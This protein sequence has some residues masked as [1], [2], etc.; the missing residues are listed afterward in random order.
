MKFA[1]RPTGAGE[2]FQLLRDG[3][4]R[5]RS[6]LATITGQARSTIAAR[7]DVLTAAGLITSVGEASSTG[8]RRPATFAF[9]PTARIVL[10]VD[11]GA[12]HARVAVADLAAAIVVNHD[13]PL[14]IADGPEKVLARVI[15]LGKDLVAESGHE[16]SDL[17]AVGIGLPG[18]VEHA[19]GR[20]VAPP[21]MPG[22]DGYDVAGT[23]RRAFGAPALVDNDVNLM[24]VGEQRTSWHEHTNMLFVKVATGIGSGIILDGTLRRGAQGAAGDIGHIALPGFSEAPCN[25]GNYGCL[26]AVAGGAALARALRE[27]ELD[28]DGTADVVA[29]V[30]DGN[31]DARAAVRDAGREVGTILAGCVSMLNPSLVVVGGALVGAGEQ[32]M[33]G[34]REVLYRRSLPLAT[35]HLRVVTSQT[36][37]SA[38]VLG[39]AYLAIDHVLSPTAIDALFA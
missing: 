18:P 14:R 32:L 30:K 21:I 27:K 10:G 35:E 22:W 28:V 8:G 34:I 31:A 4:P 5:T 3:T 20:P 23:L 12:S 15:Q 11:L 2:M 37:D 17:A 26:E 9:N 24:A 25:C 39:G 16:L 29:A 38:G 36:R 33:A 1:P 6:E 7:I 19:T 13:E